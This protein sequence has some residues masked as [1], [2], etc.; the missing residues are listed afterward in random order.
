MTGADGT[1][2]TDGAIALVAFERRLA[3]PVAA[4]WAALTES[5]QLAEWLGR[6]TLEVR[7]AGLKGLVV[8]VNELH[9]VVL[10]EE[11]LAAEVVRVDLTPYLTAGVNVVQYNPVGRNGSASVTVI[12]D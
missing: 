8:H 6:G 1:L 9:D 2:V 3:H 12:V 11:D 7:P 4:V 10:K 5:D